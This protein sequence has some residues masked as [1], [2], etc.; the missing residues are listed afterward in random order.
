[1]AF[2]W[3][4][5]CPFDSTCLHVFDGEGPS[6]TWEHILLN[7]VVTFEGGIENTRVLDIKSRSEA[8]GLQH[9]TNVYTCND[10]SPGEKMDLWTQ[11]RPHSSCTHDSRAKFHLFTCFHKL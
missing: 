1:M 9:W 10:G 3:S 7:R 5:S 4:P 6:L 8:W 2:F 11:P